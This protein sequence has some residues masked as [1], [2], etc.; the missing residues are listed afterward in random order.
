MGIDADQNV[1]KIAE[2]M[3]LD[4]RIGVFNPDL[5]TDEKFDYITLDQVLEHSQDPV[6]MLKQIEA[7]LEPEGKII[8]SLPNAFGL[9]AR[10]FGK[11]WIHWHTPYHLQFFS[12]KSLRNLLEQF[13]SLSIEST[14]NITHSHWIFYQ[15]LALISYPEN[16]TSSVFWTG[17]RF[18]LLQKFLRKMFGAC[19]KLGAFQIYTRILDFSGLGDNRIVILKRG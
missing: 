6:A 12:M 8:L 9:N 18:N 10:I 3:D 4:I 2:A 16:G 1:A 14:K 7:S 11:R 5:I 17:G 13:P 15:M 19:L